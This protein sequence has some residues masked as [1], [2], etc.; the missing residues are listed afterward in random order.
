MEH[1][2]QRNLS[3]FCYTRFTS[4]MV[5]PVAALDIVLSANLPKTQVYNTFSAAVCQ[6]ATRRRRSAAVLH[7]MFRSAV[8]FTATRSKIYYWDLQLFSCASIALLFATGILNFDLA[9]QLAFSP[10]EWRCSGRAHQIHSS[11]VCKSEMVL[12]LGGPFWWV[13]TLKIYCLKIRIVTDSLT[14]QRARAG[15]SDLARSPFF[16]YYN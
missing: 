14:L 11:F 13:R 5:L 6:A 9:F 10:V 3:Q 12:S 8:A 1:N 2:K 15:Y 7:F 4:L 16:R